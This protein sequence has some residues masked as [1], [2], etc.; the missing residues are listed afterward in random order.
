M[1]NMFLSCSDKKK[2]KQKSKR[3]LTPYH[4]EIP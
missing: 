2:N 1:Y 3:N 4:T